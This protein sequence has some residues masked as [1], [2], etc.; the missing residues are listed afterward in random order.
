MARL[1]F[2]AV[3][4]CLVASSLAG[5]LLR[6]KNP[7]MMTPI[8][9]LPAE[10]IHHAPEGSE[11][12]HNEDG[13]FTVH[14]ASG[15][16]VTSDPKCRRHVYALQGIPNGWTAYS[17]YGLD[18]SAP[19]SAFLGSWNVP[20][21]PSQQDL[22]TLFL[23]TGLQNGYFSAPPGG[24]SI[25]QPVLQY[26]PSAAGGGAY[27]A[28]ASWYVSDTGAVY[29]SLVT[30]NSGDTI[31]GNMT[32]DKTSKW[33]INTVSK[34]TGKQTNINVR[35][36]TPELFAFC[37]LEV[38]GVQACNDFP[39][40]Q[41]TFTGLKLTTGATTPVVPQWQTETQND[42]NEAVNIINPNTVS[43]AF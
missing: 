23:F 9:E 34:T 2:V 22:Q 10:C 17:L 43:I 28:I 16:Q 15:K 42:C 31:F 26:G 27:W 18:T 12:V 3:L 36:G 4:L 41:V 20:G 1:L 14:H 7:K 32:I 21:T 35:V 33:F 5:G 11:V 29:S 25:I 37:T 8:G 19:A 40:G 30:V 6:H 39:N 13:T 38:Y 24:I